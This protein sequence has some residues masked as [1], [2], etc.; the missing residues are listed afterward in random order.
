MERKTNENLI[1]DRD[2]QVGDDA[3]SQEDKREI[4]QV[5]VDLWLMFK[6]ICH[7]FRGTQE[8]GRSLMTLEGIFLPVFSIVSLQLLFNQ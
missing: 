4:T 3:T 5:V 6:A 7:Q 8:N 2:D 1:G